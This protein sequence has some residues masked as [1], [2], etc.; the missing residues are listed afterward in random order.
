MPRQLA[1]LRRSVPLQ[2]QRKIKILEDRLQGASVR[3][4]DSLTR[5]RALRARIDSLRCER[6]LFEEL[7]GKLQRGAAR[8]KT[9]IMELIA[10]IAASHEAREKVG[11]CWGPV[12]WAASVPAPRQCRP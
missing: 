11:Q 8:K 2:L 9:E 4:N 10:R 12:C 6:L 1:P 7:H 3:Y 5:S